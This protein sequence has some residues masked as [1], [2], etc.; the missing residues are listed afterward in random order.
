MIHFIPMFAIVALVLIFSLI[1][2]DWT[3]IFPKRSSNFTIKLG[4]YKIVYNRK[5]GKITKNK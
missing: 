5:T 2:G 3:D 1:F 4:S